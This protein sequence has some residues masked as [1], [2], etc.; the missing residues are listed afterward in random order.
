VAIIALALFAVLCTAAAAAAPA[1]APHQMAQP[2]PAAAPGQPHP[3]I[4][5]EPAVGSVAK[6]EWPELVGA[7]VDAAVAAIER[8]RPDLLLVRPTAHDSIVSMDYAVRRVRVFFDPAT[9]R[10]VRPPH[11]G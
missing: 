10:V 4:Y 11:V 6:V 2:Q 1:R 9:R 3:D 7:D 8:E 5:A